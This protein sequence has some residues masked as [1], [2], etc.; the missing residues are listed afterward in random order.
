MASTRARATSVARTVA[1]ALSAF[2]AVVAAAAAAV[3]TAAAA[4]SAAADAL[5]AEAAAL[6]ANA[7]ALSA[8]AA[9]LGGDAAIVRAFM[10]RFHSIIFA[11]RGCGNGDQD[12]WIRGLRALE[13]TSR[14]S[15]RR[16]T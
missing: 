13:Q 6:N 3:S 14:R 1:R 16:E 2:A 8:Q 15:L 11:K 4:L 10:K 12:S 7:A 5:S 9:A